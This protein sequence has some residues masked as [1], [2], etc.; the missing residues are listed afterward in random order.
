MNK[1]TRVDDLK[2]RWKNHRIVSY[3]I[4]FVIIIIGIANLKDSVI[5]LLDLDKDVKPEK[6][7]NGNQSI[8][9]N[10]HDNSQIK[11]FIGH[12]QNNYFYYDTNKLNNK[13][14]DDSKN[15]NKNKFE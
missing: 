5:S 9:I 15:I 11:N 14:R 7:K 2:D 3:I 4:F 10:L 13:I 1:R 8:N 12:D 6:N